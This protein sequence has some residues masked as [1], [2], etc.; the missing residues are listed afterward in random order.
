M[1]G[2][3][4]LLGYNFV[5]CSMD[6]LVSEVQSRLT[7]S[8]KTFIVTVN[9]EIVTYAQSDSNYEKVLK[10]ADYITPDGVGIIFASKIYRKPLQE[11]IPGFDLMGR[12][13]FLSNQKRYR[14]YLLGTKPDII[15][16]T[17]ENIQM[18]YPNIEI[19]GFH[20]GYFNEDEE[21][22]I[23]EELKQMK[24]DIVFVGIGFPNQEKWISN[25]LDQFSKGVFIGVGGSLNVWA[26]VDKRAPKIW[27]KLNLEWFYRLIK[28]P[29]RS[30]RMLAIPI[31]IKRVLLKEF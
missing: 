15:G 25:N 9:P 11:R 16:Q 28:Q 6:S 23:I 29:S 2:F 14:I 26:G 7:R 31:F 27:R 12:L 10:S 19:V 18:K 13:L 21:V 3:I 22:I 5:N 8:Q 24:P 17:V 20:H 1:L 30:K 4:K